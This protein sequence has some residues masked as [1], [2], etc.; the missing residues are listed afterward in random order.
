MLYGRP[1]LPNDLAIDPETFSLLRYL[2][3]LGTFQQAIQELGDKVPPAPTKGEK[4]R[5]EPEE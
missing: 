1:F 5:I 4:L 3:D 2:I